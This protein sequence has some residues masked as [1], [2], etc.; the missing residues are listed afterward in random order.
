MPFF[1]G[2]DKC[3]SASSKR[4]VYAVRDSIHIVNNKIYELIRKARCKFVPIM[5]GTFHII[6]CRSYIGINHHLLLFL[7]YNNPNLHSK[8]TIFL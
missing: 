6:F 3:C 2:S 4:L 7:V 5:N 8:D 1:W